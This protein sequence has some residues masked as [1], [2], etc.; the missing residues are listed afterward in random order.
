MNMKS[1]TM[2]I[3]Q[4]KK[5]MSGYIDLPDG[6]KLVTHKTNQIPDF[7][8]EE[9]NVQATLRADIPSYLVVA[10]NV[11]VAN[12]TNLLSIFN[13]TAKR[14]RIQRISVYVRT[15]AENSI[16]LQV[17]Y[18]NSA[19]IGSTNAIITRF[20]ADYPPNDA[21]PLTDLVNAKIL[22]TSPNPIANINLGGAAIPLSSTNPSTFQKHD[23]F[24][25]DGNGSALILRP[26]AQDGITITDVGQTATGGNITIEVILTLD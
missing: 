21:T 26:N 20:A 13:N 5:K 6:K 18:I 23:L 22:P 9:V 17:G 2:E 3:Q 19:P 24:K 16:V 7:P 8:N 14:V 11:A 1:H 10:D 25:V 15:P 12:N 4:R